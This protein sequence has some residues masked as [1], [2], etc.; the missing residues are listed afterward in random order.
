MFSK[1]SDPRD[2]FDLVDFPRECMFQEALVVRRNGVV[3]YEETLDRM[4]LFTEG[5]NSSTED[6]LWLLQHPPVYTRGM[7]CSSTTL[8]PS[9]VPV[10]KTDRGGQITYHGPGQ[11]VCYVLLDL[12]RRHTGIKQLVN[13]LEQVVIDL[14]SGYGIKGDRREGAPGVYII[15]KKIAAL[16]LRVRKG[17]SYHGLSLNVDMDLSPFDNIDPCGFKGLQATQLRDLGVSPSWVDLER[18]LVKLFVRTFSYTI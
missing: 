7:S 9:H 6:E 15:E 1:H 2:G 8:Q 4:R 5:R 3:P 13:D 11:L 14:L 16:G 18:D 10:V 17:C 12:K